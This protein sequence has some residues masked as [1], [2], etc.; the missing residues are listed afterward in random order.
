LPGVVKLW[1]ARTG[2]ERHSLTGHTAQV[3]DVCFSPD[4]RRLATAAALWDVHRGVYAGGE[5]KLWD[6]A[7]GLETLSLRG[8]RLGVHG[9]CFSPDG[10]WLASAAWDDTIHIWDSSH[11]WQACPL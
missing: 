2:K 8:H 5:V 7:A 9:V 3:A 6:V 1:D 10:R 4:G 11:P